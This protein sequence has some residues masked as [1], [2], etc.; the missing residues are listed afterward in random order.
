MIIVNRGDRLGKPYG[1]ESFSAALPLVIFIL[2]SSDAKVPTLKFWFY[3]A[4]FL[5]MINQKSEHSSR[6]CSVAV[7]ASDLQDLINFGS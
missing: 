3:G 6:K 7:R 5:C 2:A 1:Q 4:S